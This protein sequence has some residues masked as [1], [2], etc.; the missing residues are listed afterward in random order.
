MTSFTRRALKAF[1][2]L[3]LVTLSSA[4]FA[5]VDNRPG[6]VLVFPYYTS[7]G[8]ASADTQITIANPSSI[9]VDVH[10][11]FID[12]TF[13]QQG[14]IP[15]AL[16]PNATVTIKMSEYDPLNSGYLIA[17]AQDYNGNVTANAAITGNAFIKAPAGYI[18]V[19]AGEIRGD[20]GA[21]GFRAIS[22][23]APVD[24]ILE[25]SFDG[26]KLEKMPRMFGAELQN[27]TLAPGQ[28]I[29]IAGMQGDVSTGDISGAAA[30]GVGQL[31]NSYEEVRSFSGFVKGTCHSISTFTNSAPRVTVPG[32]I[33]TFISAGTVGIMK[34]PTAGGVGILITPRNNAGWSGIRTLSYLTTTNAKLFVPAF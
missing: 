24:G 15:I 32:G 1:F 27:P 6:S 28:T 2:L 9:P 8:D 20:Y 14:D 17:V 4:I 13:C 22:P 26:I 29:I 5:Q 19:G 30:N 31:F 34:F 12:R 25:L 21:T 16:T 33:N 11:Y 23:T 3:A 10:L 7:N 18:S